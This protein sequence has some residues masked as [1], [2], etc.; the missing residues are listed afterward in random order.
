MCVSWI[1]RSNGRGKGADLVVDASDNRDFDA[2]LEDDAETAKPS[3]VS[4]APAS[5]TSG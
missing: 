5:P 3:Q 2:T 1:E 4:K